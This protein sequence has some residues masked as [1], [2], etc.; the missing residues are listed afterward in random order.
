MARDEGDEAPTLAAD[1]VQRLNSFLASSRANV[2]MAGPAPPAHHVVGSSSARYTRPSGPG[3]QALSHD[4]ASRGSPPPLST[5][6]AGGTPS[7]AGDRADS[8]GRLGS[9]DRG[10]LAHISRLEAPPGRPEHPEEKESRHCGRFLAVH[11]DYGHRTATARALVDSGNI[12]RS[13]ISAQFAKE[14]GLQDKDL[15]PATVNT[16]GTAKKGAHLKILGEPKKTLVLRVVGTESA[17]PFQPIVVEGL[18]MPINLSG[19]WMKMCQWDHLHGKDALRINGRDVQLSARRGPTTLDGGHRI[20]AAEKTQLAGRSLTFIAACVP[21]IKTGQGE[22]GTGVVE[23]GAELAGRQLWP[24]QDA[25]M[26]C[27]PD[28][29]MPVAV[30]NLGDEPLTIAAG[31]N[32]G[33]YFAAEEADS[34]QIAAAG[35]LDD[36]SY[37]AAKGN[38]REKASE[39]RTQDEKARQRAYYDDLMVR[40]Q[41]A[42]GERQQLAWLREA[43]Q[44]DQR[45]CLRTT[46]DKLKAAQVLREYWDLFSHDG[47][48]GYTH[49]LKHRI[50]TEDVPPIKCRYRPVSPHLEASLRQQLNEWLNHGVIEPSNSPWS[51]N[52][53][54]AKKK[55]GS[56]RWCVD[57]RR[58]NSVTKKDSFPM[59]MIGDTLTRLGGSKIFSGVD[60]SGAFHCI[61]MEPGDKEKTAFAT[62]FGSFQQRR[63]GF[64]LT[65]G[66]A[67]YCRLVDLVLKEVPDSVAVSFLDDGVV[68]SKT[69]E[70]HF[71]NLRVTLDAYRAAGLKLNPRKCTF[72]AE[73]V[74]YLGH[75]INASG[76]RPMDSYKEAVAK[77]P[78]P[79]LKTEA[80]AFLGLVGYYRDHI[81]NYAAIAKPWSEITGKTDAAEEKRA[82]QV[83]PYMKW[84]FEELK[85]RLTNAP[86]MGF[87]YFHGP[88]AGRFTLDTDF[89]KRQISGILSQE[90]DGKEVVLAYKSKALN[91]HQKNWP[92]T[93][94]ELYAGMF[95]MTRYSY[96]L[97]H[98]PL[99]R[100]RT[101]NDALRWIRTMDP[102]SSIIDRWLTTIADYHFEVEHRAGAKHT[103]ADG[104]SRYGYPERPEPEEEDD[105]GGRPTIQATTLMAAQGRKYET[106]EMRR[107]Q[108]EDE[109]V[110]RARKWVA[111]KVKPDALT[112]KGL[113]R[114]G[115]IYAG[116]L[117]RL[118]LDED[119]ILMR[120]EP[121]H[122]F[123]QNAKRVVLPRSIWDE[124]IRTAHVAGGHQATE[125]TMRRIRDYAFIPHLYGEVKGYVDACVTCQAKQQGQRDQRH[126]LVSPLAGYPFQRLHLDFVG[127]LNEGRRTGAKW[128]LTCRDSFSKWVEA[129]P[130]RRATAEETVRALEREVFSRFGPPES[131]HSDSGRQ[132]ES[133]L[134]RDVARLLGIQTT[135]TGGYNPKGNGAV[136][137]MHRDL[138]TMLRA[139]V[140]EDPDSWEDALPWALF[141]IRTA[142]CR[143]TGLAPYQILFGR[144]CSQPLD[145]MFKAPEDDLLKGNRDHHEYVRRLDQRIHRVQKFVREQGLEAVRRQRRQ[146]HKDRKSFIPGAKVFLFTPTT[147]P[148]TARK[149]S[150]FWTGPWTVC[151]EPTGSETMVR[152]APHP[153]WTHIKGTKVVSIDRLKPYGDAKKAYGPQPEDDLDMEGDEF[154][155]YVAAPGGAAPPAPLP[156]LGGGPLPPGGG[157]P[158]P[159]GG[160]PPPGGGAPPP[161]GGAPPPGGGAPPPGGGLPAPGG[162]APPPGGEAPQPAAGAQPPGAVAP[163]RGPQAEGQGGARRRDP[164]PARGRSPRARRAQPRIADRADD[165]PPRDRS[166]IRPPMGR[167]P[168]GA[169]RAFDPFGD[170]QPPQRQAIPQGRQLARTPPP[171]GRQLARTPPPEGRPQR[172]RRPP[173]RYADHH[174]DGAEGGRDPAHSSSSSEGERERD[175][176]DPDWRPY[177][178]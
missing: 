111:E 97:K 112:V 40:G 7:Q 175:R 169:A 51:S 21:A 17:Y 123:Q 31:D 122:P 177:R 68:H 162:A 11:L 83:T 121:N 39:G 157:A 119:G 59:P 153:T 174:A 151:S 58:L 115:K 127:P 22:A 159:G 91:K 173:D 146:Y 149:L 165:L 3:G 15:Q 25:L 168:A 18:S 35:N 82:I 129:I 48:Y 80:R 10:F 101:D 28:G 143:S 8:S 113:S 38:H 61:E 96:Y 46:E 65:N 84:A 160:A 42:T 56:I 52:L 105:A 45:P 103:N 170:A 164:R 114:V 102:P 138:G 60:M 94:G 92:S 29:S 154:A 78:L 172:E 109:D 148:G 4:I 47:S 12:W 70:D 152:I 26:R 144:N 89:S 98:A 131:I 55:D 176:R 69:V 23:G 163:G 36:R 5:G 133:A 85:W 100:W 120:A 99:F 13:A 24:C 33:T 125:A 86:V 63:L 72:F 20:Y 34:P 107:L 87:P 108:A 71:Q 104:L 110:G 106:D 128:I 67:T 141:A 57:W 116:E 41:K 66:P 88:K 126:T 132:F 74:T 156:G 19:P 135:T 9:G 81:P 145:L 137:R 79:R 14:I 76:I 1:F 167:P 44:L 142:V 75:T 139:A 134:F 124:V 155:E 136:E 16:V 90:Q 130:L 77:W 27:Q 158:P 62:P 2:S 166:P 6:L 64:G 147:K 30:W 95:Y 73:E 49:L 37:R 50:I 161:G 117:E 118:T 150:T 140:R 171:Q 53:V 93:K 43:F 54:A 178:R 32:L